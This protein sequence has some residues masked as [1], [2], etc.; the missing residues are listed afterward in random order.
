MNIFLAYTCVV[1]IWATTPLAIHWSNH[2]VDFITAISARVVIAAAVGFMV[3]KCLRMQ[4]LQ[5]RHELKNF[6][7]GALGV[8]PTMFL[9][10]YAAQYIPSGLMSVLFGLFP[11]VVGVLSHW[12]LRERVL[13]PVKIAALIL[14]FMGLVVI[15]IDQLR[16]G[17]QAVLGVVLMVIATLCWGFSTIWLKSLKHVVPAF[18]Q[19]VGSLTL[20]APFFVFMWWQFAGPLPVGLGVKS[21]FGV[22]YL[23]LIGSLLGH[24]L[25]F[26]VLQKCQVANVALIPLITPVMAMAL[27]WWLEG[28]VFS[29]TALIG[30]A[31]VLVA[32]AVFQ[33]VYK[34]FTLRRSV[35]KPA[36]F[37]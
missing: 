34:R 14:A 26:Y 18:R 24:T 19:S 29:G 30:A 32:L 22:G 35:C 21:L 7:A 25:F 13:T 17:A 15:N 9:V 37:L 10:Y 1:L 31:M 20:V 36:G 6:A 28:E 11:F 33:G 23:A 16:L 8:F 2:D 27:G 4:I 3:A 5:H 12:L